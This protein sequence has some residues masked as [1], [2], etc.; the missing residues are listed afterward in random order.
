MGPNCTLRNAQ[1]ASHGSYFSSLCSLS[2]VFPSLVPLLSSSLTGSFIVSLPC[3]F[4]VL[5]PHWFLRCLSP[6]CLHHHPPSLVPSP[7]SLAGAI[8]VLTPL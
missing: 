8:V 5:L 6:S 7:S 1:Q 2:P 3:A 4:V